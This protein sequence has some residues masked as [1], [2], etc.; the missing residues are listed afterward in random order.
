MTNTTVYSFMKW[1]AL[2]NLVWILVSCHNSSNKPDVSDIKL[3]VKIERFDQDF[4]SIDTNNITASL[5]KVNKDYPSFLRL[6][7]EFLTPINFMVQQQ[8]KSYEEAVRIYLR[9]IKPLYDDVQKKYSNLQ[10]V[11]NDLQKSF[12]YVK[13]YFPD[14]KLPAVF[15]SVENLN[16]EEPQEIYGTALYHDTLIIS[17]QMFMG[18]DFAA[19]DPTQYP[20]YLRRRFEA[21]FMVPNCIRAIA[22]DLHPDTSETNTLIETMIEKG[23]QWYLMKRFLPDSP[24]SLITGYSSNQMQ[25]VEKNEGNI[26]TEFLKD[27]PD[28]YTVDQDRFKNYIGE[29][30]FTQDMPHDLE[31]NGTPGN[32]GQWMGWRIVEKF[33]AANS[34]LSLQQILNTPARKIFQEAKYKPK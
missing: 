28:P 1:F 17:L 25:F 24:D 13:H 31:G 14:Y 34:N 15:A 33:A 16:P 7:S 32:I 26:W 8:G 20:D 21:P 23:K 11:Q 2:A 4:F 9:T 29:A 3:N 22:N 5:T 6:Y 27:T 10:G 19:Y 30:P 12:K 18:K